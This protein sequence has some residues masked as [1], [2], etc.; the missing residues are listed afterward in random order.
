MKEHNTKSSSSQH[1]HTEGLDDFLLS[2][3]TPSAVKVEA[4]GEVPGAGAPESVAIGD[5]LKELE[6]PAQK[7]AEAQV[8]RLPAQ[9]G[10]GA[11]AE[12]GPL[13]M[14]LWSEVAASNARDFEA[15][16][17]VL[18]AE[19]DSQGRYSLDAQQNSMLRREVLAWLDS[20]RSQE[21][22]RAQ[23][24]SPMV[25]DHTARAIVRQLLEAAQASPTQVWSTC[26]PT[27]RPLVIATAEALKSTDQ[28]TLAK[29]VHLHA[30][31]GLKAANMPHD[32][33]VLESYEQAQ[34]V[35]A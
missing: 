25:R 12:Q 29:R 3:M 9:L 6:A 19:F 8:V 24:L 7:Q 18:Q 2:N 34:E 20:L 15:A 4:G 23:L 22:L 33:K 16:M 14:A 31:R 10:D 1:V 11:A 17:L 28:E 27:G 32:A 26:L 35:T 13:P 30:L 21:Q 5:V